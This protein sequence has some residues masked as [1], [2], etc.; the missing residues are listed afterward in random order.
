MFVIRH[1]QAFLS[2]GVLV[3]ALSLGAVAVFG[4]RPSIEFSGGSVMEVRY[5]GAVPPLQDARAALDA[6][7]AERG[8]ASVQPSGARGFV[9]RTTAL[10]QRSLEAFADALSFGG[11]YPASVARR[12]TVGP[13]LGAEL[14]NKA[15]AAIALVVAAIVFFVAFAFRGVGR[16]PVA[17]GRGV[18]SWHFGLAT[19]LTLL[20]D[21]A[22]PAGVFAA[23]GALRGIEI[24]AL[25]ITALLA[26][27][28]YSVN[29]TIVVFDRV[30]ENVIAARDR[31]SAERFSD[32][33]GRSVSETYARSLN[34]SLTTLF[35]LCALLLFGPESTRLFALALAVGIAAGTYSSIVLASPLLVVFERLSARR[36]ARR[37]AR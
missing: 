30:R 23:L 29:D 28:G 1:Y 7:R 20:H 13:S 11:E 2:F 14:K 36:E 33:V 35:V 10:D 24:D 25:F 22:V 31:R 37:A 32:I 3:C 26:V 16:V 5:E 17:G 34:T 21:V 19:V 27:L 9:V 15:A 6:L 8:A 4:L 18:S 12:A